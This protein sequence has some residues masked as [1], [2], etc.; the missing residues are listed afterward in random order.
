MNRSSNTLPAS[1]QPDPTMHNVPFCRSYSTATY[2]PM[3]PLQIN[4]FCY[5]PI[6]QG[7]CPPVSQRLR[8]MEVRNTIN[9]PDTNDADD[10]DV[11]APS[12]PQ[13]IPHHPGVA[14]PMP[15]VIPYS[16]TA[17]QL[18][19]SRKR[20]HSAGDM[21]GLY[22]PT[23]ARLLYPPSNH[24]TMHAPNFHS[25]NNDTAS[26]NISSNPTLPRKWL[27][28]DQASVSK[29]DPNHQQQAISFSTQPKPIMKKHFVSNPSQPANS[30]I[31]HGNQAA[32]HQIVASSDNGK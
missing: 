2:Q 5:A 22:S 10:D 13:N 11:F 16:P 3:Y 20:A 30:I 21:I 7:V 1:Y 9:L 31:N 28:T 18:L 8:S 24:I 19:Q 12:A 17:L 26:A 15:A 29:F 25:S 4:S 32:V 14:L 27:I 6:H 23:V